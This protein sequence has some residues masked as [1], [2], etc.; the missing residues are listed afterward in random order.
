MGAV[1][2]CNCGVDV[3]GRYTSCAAR[4]SLSLPFLANTSSLSILF[5]L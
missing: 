3:A 1:K 4:Q 2:D 5:Y